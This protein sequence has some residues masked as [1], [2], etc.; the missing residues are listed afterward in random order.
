MDNILLQTFFSMVLALTGAV[1]PQPAEQSKQPEP[2]SQVSEIKKE[3][4]VIQ[5][6]APTVEV[7]PTQPQ[8]QPTTN[9]TPAPA[10]QATGYENNERHGAPMYNNM[11][12]KQYEDSIMGL[13]PSQ[14]PDNI[15]TQSGGRSRLN[16]IGK[17]S[18]YISGVV[19][20]NTTSNTAYYP[21]EMNTVIE[22]SWD[23]WKTYGYGQTNNYVDINGNIVLVSYNWSSL[24]VTG[25]GEY[26]NQWTNY[27]RQLDN[28]Y[29]NKCPNN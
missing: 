6:S 17:Y 14:V 20:H 18:K 13:C 16:S 28:T 21:Y 15:W 9:Q 8:P 4:P 22:L 26:D 1:Q 10:Q 24:S 5:T 2:V 3:E 25:A 7:Q 19:P 29:R 23:T 12:R 27:L 11:P